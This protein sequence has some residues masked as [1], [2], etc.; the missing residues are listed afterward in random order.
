MY[1]FINILMWLYNQIRLFYYK[2]IRRKCRHFCLLCSH[3]S[4]CIKNVGIV[5]TINEFIEESFTDFINNEPI[6][7][8]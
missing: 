5:E 1:K 8:L 3:K 6:G 4:W 7:R 2:W